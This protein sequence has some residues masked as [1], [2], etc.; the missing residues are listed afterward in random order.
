MPRRGAINASGA[1]SDRHPRRAVHPRL[2]RH[3]RLFLARRADGRRGSTMSHTPGVCR[4]CAGPTSNPL[5]N[6]CRPCFHRALAD[7]RKPTYRDRRDR[8]CIDCGKLTTGARCFACRHPGTAEDRFWALVDRGAG[9]TGCWLWRGSLSL[10]YASFGG[11]WGH[12]L[13]YEY[14]IGPIPAGLELDHLCRTTNCVNPAHLEPVTHAENMRRGAAA[15]R[16][17]KAA[18]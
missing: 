8:P 15:R 13:A 5:A 17:A 12:R 4:V 14:A 18:A 9:A 2:L 3:G 16:A 7:S 6:R 11:V 10:G 1:R